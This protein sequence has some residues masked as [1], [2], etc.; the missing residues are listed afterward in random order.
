MAGAPEEWFV[1]LRRVVFTAWADIVDRDTAENS[2]PAMISGGTLTVIVTPS[3]AP[4]MQIQEPVIL[5]R[6]NAYIGLFGNRGFNRIRLTQGRIDAHP[7]AAE[8]ASFERHAALVRDS[9][10]RNASMPGGAGHRAMRTGA[11]APR[12]RQ[13]R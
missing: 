4:T 9:V 12:R 2:R 10:L 8:T 6:I 1:R 13:R 5:A 7:D 11:A 3:H